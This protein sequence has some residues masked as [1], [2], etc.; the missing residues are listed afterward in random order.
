MQNTGFDKSLLRYFFLLFLGAVIVTLF[1]G[2]HTVHT[3]YLQ[4]PGNFPLRDGYH[5]ELHLPRSPTH[6]ILLGS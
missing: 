5:K 2:A 6:Y 3:Y 4:V 1:P